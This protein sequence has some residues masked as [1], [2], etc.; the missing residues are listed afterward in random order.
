VCASSS[1]EDRK[2]WRAYGKECIRTSASVAFRSR[3]VTQCRFVL[4]VATVFFPTLVQA[5]DGDSNPAVVHACVQ[6]SSKQVRIVGVNGACSN[7][8][9]TAHWAISGPQGPAGLKARPVW[10]PRGCR[11]QLVNGPAGPLRDQPDLPGRRESRDPPADGP[12]G[13]N[14]ADGAQ[15]ATGPAGPAGTPAVLAFNIVH[16]LPDTRLNGGQQNNVWYVLTKRTLPV[17][18]VSPTSKLKITYQDTL[19]PAHS[20]ITRVSGGS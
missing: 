8:E 16:T 4:A 20:P 14:G 12:P 7:S 19:G 6:Q 10:R 3:F 17:N 18:K 13:L 9:T 1:Y 11:E 5:H 2:L 15:G